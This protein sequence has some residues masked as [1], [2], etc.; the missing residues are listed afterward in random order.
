MIT[1]TSIQKSFKAYKLAKGIYVSKY[2]KDNQIIMI[3]TFKYDSFND[4]YDLTDNESDFKDVTIE[5]YDTTNFKCIFTQAFN[6]YDDI[7]DIENHP[8]LKDFGYSSEEYKYI[9]NLLKNASYITEINYGTI[10]TI[11]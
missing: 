3:R 2:K 7:S 5:V 11:S 1:I 8:K 6:Y 9:D 10:P 4:Y